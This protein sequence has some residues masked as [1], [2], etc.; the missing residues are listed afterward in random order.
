MAIPSEKEV[1][2]VVFSFDKNKA[3]S[4]DGFPLFFFQTFWNIL[5]DDVVKGVQEFSGAK[6]ILKELNSTFL[7]LIP[8]I[9]GAYSMDKFRSISLCNSFY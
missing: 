8:K 7:V 1:K 3:P 9:P 5:K 4:L 6:M 2:K